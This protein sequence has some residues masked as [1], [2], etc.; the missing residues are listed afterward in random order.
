MIM[1]PSVYVETTIISYLTAWRSPQLVTAAHQEATWDWWDNSRRNFNLFVSEAVVREASAGDV[2]AA[3][4]RLES[5]K[6][7]PDLQITNEARDLA[8]VLVRKG[9]FPSTASV[10]ILHVAV[11]LSAYRQ[12]HLSRVYA[13]SL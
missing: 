5:I 4:R 9:G 12:R 8:K 10:D 13:R 11:E 2:E 7:I 6:G 3:K 1:K